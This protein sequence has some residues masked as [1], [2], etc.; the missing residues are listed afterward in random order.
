MMS[1]RS[2][3]ID[4]LIVTT[5]D[6]D[7]QLCSVYSTDDNLRSFAKQILWPEIVA[8][9]LVGKGL[10]GRAAQAGRGGIFFFSDSRSPESLVVRQYRHGGFWR[11]LSGARFFSRDRFLAELK[12]HN[13]AAELG[14]LVPEAVA[15]IVVEKACK[16]LFLN[17]YF[18]TIRLQ[19]SLTLPD[20]LESASRKT[21]LMIFSK[22]GNYL[23]ILH[24]HGIFYTDIHVKNILLTSGGEPCFIDFDKSKEFKAPLSSALR[25]AN[26]RRFLRSLEKYCHRGGR[27]TE[28][29]RAAFL[30]AYEPASE[31]YVKLY[32]QLMRGL[33]W[34]R[35]FYRLGWWLNRS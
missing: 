28:S 33:F 22:I 10:D 24:E 31:T 6:L 7:E 4:N 23:R 30:I 21:R 32:Q 26:I 15:V 25:Q 29:D 5:F 34:R 11:F 27:L 35:L 13:R 20:F 2:L 8:D 12:V 3:P 17:G 9:L 14:V 18:A 19:D 1:S 16:G